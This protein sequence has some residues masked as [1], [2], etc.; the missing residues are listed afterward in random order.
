[1]GGISC[2]IEARVRR[3]KQSFQTAAECIGELDH[4]MHLFAITRGQFSMIDA[5]LAV[6]DQTGKARITIWTWTIAAYEVGMFL[7]LLA[8]ERIERGSL[9]VIDHGARDKNMELIQKWKAAHGPGS[10]KFVVNHAKICTVQNAE[11]RVL[12]RGSMNLNANPK[13]EQLDITE[14]L[15]DFDLVRDEE[16]GIETL[17]DG[18]PGSEVVRVS[19]IC[20]AWD[21]GQL[22]LFGGV[23]RWAK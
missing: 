2:R 7:Q 11:W 13:F 8:D 17:D 22:A 1:M 18:A 3:Q 10:V 15:P 12:L 19:R 4:G 6:L 21:P 5:V 20:G 23:K 14:G 16:D 9:L